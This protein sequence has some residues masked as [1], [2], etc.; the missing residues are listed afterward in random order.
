[1]AGIYNQETCHHSRPLPIEGAQC[2]LG[3]STLTP[4]MS[5]VNLDLLTVHP[6]NSGTSQ[7]E[8]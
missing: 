2:P 3:F 7:A 5:P 6:S 8:I 1:M 4:P